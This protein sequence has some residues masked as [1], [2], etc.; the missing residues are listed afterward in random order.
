MDL[1]V[2]SWYYLAA[3]KTLDTQMCRDTMVENYCIIEA[4]KQRVVLV[5]SIKT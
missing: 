5:V 2:K 1:K 3:V 4:A